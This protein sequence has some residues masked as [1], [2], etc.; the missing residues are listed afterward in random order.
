[1]RCVNEILLKGVQGPRRKTI[2]YPVYRGFKKLKEEFDKEIMK[3]ELYK[4]PNF[5]IIEPVDEIKKHEITYESPKFF[6]KSK[7]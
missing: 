3:K 2:P 6:K 4:N 5:N 1:M 7:K